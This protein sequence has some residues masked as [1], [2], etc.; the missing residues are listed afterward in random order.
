MEQGQTSG[1]GVHV[2][3]DILMVPVKGELDDDAVKHLQREILDRAGATAVQGVLLDMS[4]VRALDA[5]TFSMLADTARMLM[6]LGKRP[7][8]VGF[9]P[10]VASALVDLDADLDNITTALTVEDGLELL[11]SLLPSW[12]RGGQ[13]EAESD[14]RTLE[15]DEPLE[16]ADGRLE[17]EEGLDDDGS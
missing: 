11:H 16:D 14:G 9:Q 8:F 15:A 17:P 3:N 2:I 5:F 4:A 6:L 13:A 1:F 7:V 12:R 10:G